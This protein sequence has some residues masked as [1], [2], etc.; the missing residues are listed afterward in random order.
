MLNSRSIEF[1]S[2]VGSGFSRDSAHYTGE[3][4]LNARWMSSLSKPYATTSGTS[5]SDGDRPECCD[6][7]TMM[8]HSFPSGS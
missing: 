4:S 3:P 7:S 6:F 8:G 1:S 2:M 5:I